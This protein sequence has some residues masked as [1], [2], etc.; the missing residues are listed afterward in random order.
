MEKI[1]SCLKR[2]KSKTAEKEQT[3]NKLNNIDDFEE[4]LQDLAHDTIKVVRSFY[5]EW[6]QF[7]L[8][9]SVFDVAVGLI[10]ANAVT[11]LTKSLVSDIILPLIVAIWR[12]G[13]L[14]NNFVILVNGKSN[15]STYTT[16]A[17]A[18]ADGAVT[19]NYG[20]FIDTAI[21]FVFTTLA[22][23]VLY[24]ALTYVRKAAEKQLEKEKALKEAAEKDQAE[25]DG[26][27]QNDKDAAEKGVAG[28]TT[29]KT[30]A[31]TSTTTEKTGTG[32][33]TAE[34]AGTATT[35][36]SAQGQTKS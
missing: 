20:S 31:A 23:F 2:K 11:A 21:N 29:E 3:T 1:S 26:V 16:L 15:N 17:A 22:V 14:S 9:Q 27:V 13:S 25:K 30:G 6:R 28:S 5:T 33:A 7:A 10:I 34:K 32:T 18:T 24:K 12:G 35:S 19:W 4:E 36:S 8:K